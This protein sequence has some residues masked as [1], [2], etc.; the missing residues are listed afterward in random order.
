M[1]AFL[2]KNSVRFF[3]G[4]LLL[5]V[6]CIVPC[7]AF[8][9]NWQSM[10]TPYSSYDDL[11]IW[12]FSGNQ[13]FV[14]GDTGKIFY[15]DGSGSDY[16]KDGTANDWEEV[17]D[18]GS[19]NLKGIHGVGN[20]VFA[21]GNNGTILRYSGDTNSDG[22]PNDW[23]EMLDGG[24]D[25]WT[26]Q[27]LFGVWCVTETDVY[28]AG[29]NETILH[30]D[31]SS[32][33]EMTV[34][35]SGSVNF[36]A[37]MDGF[38]VGS[39]EQIYK[40]SSGSGTWDEIYDD[41]SFTFNDI[42]VGADEIIVVGNN[43]RIVVSGDEG[44][45]WT[46]TLFDPDVDLNGVWVNAADAFI[47]GDTHGDFSNMGAILR[48]VDGAWVNENDSGVEENLL[49]VWGYGNDV[50][51]C[52]MDGVVV[53]GQNATLVELASFNAISLGRIVLLTWITE[54]EIDNAGFN[55]LRAEGE[56]AYAQIN[57]SLIAAKG[58]PT[59][60]A[61]Y[62]YVDVETVMGTTYSYKLADIDTEGTVTEHEPQSVTPKGMPFL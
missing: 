14:V 19:N 17:F 29:N 51:V 34:T 7:G 54:S 49:D 9:Q 23:E 37:I 22:I 3:S 24:G 33:S 40:Y 56:G 58:S 6:V 11:D 12:G 27:D 57:D 38:A 52:G 5:A 53:L 43:G 15:Y 39:G 59:A 21:V 60:G 55:I 42:W 25:P 20:T 62:V 36:R 4:C 61:V 30:F 10:S 50:F 28:A 45:T 1:G 31:G 16:D 8:A 26:S 44:D 2:R 41:G 46:E 47:V 35:D 32:W 18:A 48:R 13:V